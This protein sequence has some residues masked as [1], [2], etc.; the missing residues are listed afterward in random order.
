MSE[1][2]AV[3]WPAEWEPQSHVWLGW[4]RLPDEWGDH[5][6][7]ARREIAALAEVMAAHTPVRL[8]VGDD[9]A[10]KVAKAALPSSVERVRVP[11]GDVW[12]RDTGPVFVMRQGALEANVFA[13]NGWGGKYTMAGDT[14]TAAAMAEAS[15]TR[16]RTHPFILEGG[17]IDTNGHGQVIT[18]RQCLL[19]PNRN[20]WD[21]QAAEQALHASVGARRVHWLDRGLSGDH[22]DGHVDNIARFIAPDTVICQAATGPDDPHAARLAEIETALRETGLTVAT[23]PSPGRVTGT[24]GEALPASH[25]NF[26]ITNG[27]VIV[28]VYDDDTGADAVAVLK[29]LFPDREVIALPARAILSGGGGAFHCMTCHVPKLSVSDPGAPDP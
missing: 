10:N 14:E 3:V 25:L 23:V 9:Y 27:A 26:T 24:D 22:T 16:H 2:R 28:P 12:L 18:T 13:F 7:P 17:A 19:N 15:G 5:F 1:R 8:A 4:P 6:N 11:T 20:G 29:P 21:E